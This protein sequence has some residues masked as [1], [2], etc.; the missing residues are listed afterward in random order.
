MILRV[1]YYG[2]VKKSFPTIRVT[3]RLD[4]KQFAILNALALE[5]KTGESRAKVL[6]KIFINSKLFINKQKE[7]KENELS[8]IQDQ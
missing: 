4:P 3:V 7:L 5:S 2:I 6:K 1:V 8:A